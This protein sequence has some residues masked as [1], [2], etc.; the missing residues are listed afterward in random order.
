[1]SLSNDSREKRLDGI[2][3]GTLENAALQCGVTLQ[4]SSGLGKGGCAF[5]FD[6][7]EQACEIM[8]I[9]FVRTSGGFLKSGDLPV[10]P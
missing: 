3:G 5:A 8:S 2:I 7:D 9:R 6:Q 10:K 1:M 4:V